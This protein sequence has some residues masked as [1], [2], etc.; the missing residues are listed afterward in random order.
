M[1]D[2]FKKNKIRVLGNGSSQAWDDIEANLGSSY[3]DDM[4]VEFALSRGYERGI[5]S[6]GVYYVPD[7]PPGGEYKNRVR[8]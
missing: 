6:R 1:S 2:L 5:D 4:A 8:H 3:S 7:I